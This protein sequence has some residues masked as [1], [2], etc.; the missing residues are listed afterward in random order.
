MNEFR[1]IYISS[2]VVSPED[3]SYMIV[4]LSNNTLYKTKMPQK[5]ETQIVDFDQNFEP[6][7]L[8]FHY[9]QI[10]DMDLATRKPLIATC[11]NDKCI[12]IW[13][14]EKKSL[15]CYKY[16]TEEAYCISIHPSGL[17]LVVG[18]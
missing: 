3:E 14:Y 7:S 2:I 6:V 8:N 5:N 9:K 16:F 17:F 15:E 10:N 18:F 12:R 4:S 13:N 11:G 1:E